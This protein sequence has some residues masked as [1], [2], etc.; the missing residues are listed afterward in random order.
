MKKHTTDDYLYTALLAV[1]AFLLAAF[2]VWYFILGKPPFTACWFYSRWH[3][4][5]PG[6]GAT[7][8]VTALFRGS[9]LQALYYH[10]AVPL[11]ALF[12]AAYLLS[13][14]IWRLRGRKGKVLR[15]SDKW[16]WAL[17]LLMLLHCLARNILWFGYQIA[18]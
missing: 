11:G 5:C 3:V 10:P 15:W 2:L 8:A 4:Y 6:C 9:F 14:T 18:L 7:R 1:G 13:Q 17:L 16:F 12:L